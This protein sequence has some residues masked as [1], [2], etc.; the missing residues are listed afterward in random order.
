MDIDSVSGSGP[1]VKGTPKVG[2]MGQSQDHSS[3]MGGKKS[4]N[5]VFFSKD[6]NYDPSEDDDE[7]SVA[8]KGKGGE[9]FF[10]TNLTADGVNFESIDEENDDEI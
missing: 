9:S 8:Y 6:M 5:A 10:N 7:S 2:I 1:L 4:G 3:T